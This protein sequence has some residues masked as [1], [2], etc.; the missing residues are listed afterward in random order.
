MLQQTEHSC[1]RFSVCTSVLFH[2]KDVK[3]A[4]K[5]LRTNEKFSKVPGYIVNQ[6]TKELSYMCT[7]NQLE[8]VIEKQDHLRWQH[9]IKKCPKANTKN[10]LKKIK[11]LYWEGYKIYVNV[12]KY[13]PGQED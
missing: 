7:N 11:K 12:E 9:N 10:W 3:Y 1:V 8:N 4:K 13:V 6:Q 2:N 5:N